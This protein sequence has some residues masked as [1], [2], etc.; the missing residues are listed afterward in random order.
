MISHHLLASSSIKMLSHSRCF[1]HKDWKNNFADNKLGEANP[2]GSNTLANCFSTNLL[3]IFLL[4]STTGKVTESLSVS[5]FHGIPR[6]FDLLFSKRSSI[7]NSSLNSKQLEMNSRRF[8]WA[9]LNI[10][11]NLKYASEASSFVS[12][13][14][15]ILST[16]ELFLS[17]CAIGSSID[18]K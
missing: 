8:I 13:P 3:F 14:I 17:L 7:G 15:N 2:S 12:T 16:Y 11:F 10:F 1:S 18:S 4:F 5:I 9:V 6:I